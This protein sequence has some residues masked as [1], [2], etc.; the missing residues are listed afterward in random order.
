MNRSEQNKQ[1]VISSA[2]MAKATV[3]VNGRTH[4]IVVFQKSTRHEFYWIFQ[5]KSARSARRSWKYAN[6]YG[7]DFNLAYKP[8]TDFGSFVAHYAQIKHGEV[9][10]V[11]LHQPRRVAALLAKTEQESIHADW[12]PRDVSTQTFELVGKNSAIGRKRGFY[13]NSRNT[14]NDVMP[15]SQNEVLVYEDNCEECGK[16]HSFAHYPDGKV[17]CKMGYTEMKKH[18]G[19]DYAGYRPA[20]GFRFTYRTFAPIGA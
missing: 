6:H 17:L 20:S 4:I 3:K 13:F 16:R 7:R 11:R 5:A 1:T 15:Q 12:T 2:I 19:F 18:P 9:Q 14:A 8:Y 10:S